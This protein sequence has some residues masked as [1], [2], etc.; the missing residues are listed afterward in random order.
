MG[1]CRDPRALAIAKPLTPKQRAFV[2]RYVETGSG[3]QAARDAYPDATDFSSIA[4]ENLRNAKIRAAVKE[5]LDKQ[6]I[7][8]EKLHLIHAHYLAMYDS[9]EP[10]DRSLGLKAL[11][12]AYKLTGAYEAQNTELPE[13]FAGWTEA[14]LEAF[15]KS[16]I[17]P[18]G[19]PRR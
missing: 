14:E 3:H 16:Q 8:R 5:L 1:R 9:P 7:T 11:H 2:V 4:K 12:M 13:L 19:R 18:E 10:L 17:W 15:A 6:G